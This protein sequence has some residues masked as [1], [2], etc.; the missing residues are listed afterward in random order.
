MLSYQQASELRC[1]KTIWL[2]SYFQPVV[3]DYQIVS[4]EVDPYECRLWCVSCMG[5]GKNFTIPAGSPSEVLYKHE[6]VNIIS[7]INTFY[8]RPTEEKLRAKWFRF[9]EQGAIT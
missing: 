5:I 9:T 7:F 2:V 1:G 4:I 8:T 3:V 6:P